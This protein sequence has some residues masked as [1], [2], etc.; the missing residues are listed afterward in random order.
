MRPEWWPWL[1]RALWVTLPFTAGPLFGDAFADTS[2]PVQLV[3]TI[4]L[5]VLW[6][7]G[8][9]CMLI[10]HV[11]TLTPVRMLA[12]AAAVAAIWATIDAGTSGTAVLGLVSTLAVAI[13]AASPH[14][15]GWFVNGSS[16][17]DERRL[18]LRPPT[19]IAWGPLPLAAA[20]VIA[21]AGAAPLL[22]AA[23]QWILGGLVLVIGGALAYPALRAMH[24]LG[25][26]WLVF[27]PA[28]MVIHDS[29]V[30]ADPVLIKRTA[31]DVFGPALADTTATDL[32]MAASG[33]VLEAQLRTP[34]SLALR[35]EPG[36]Q[37]EIQELEAVLVAPTLPGAVLDE[38]ERRRIRVG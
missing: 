2:R 25:R 1:L 18:L 7:A 24:T 32:T 10:P 11:L 31:I 8:L 4:G 22:L 15:G 34:A 21:T 12:P 27:V 37:P 13:T 16:Y 26:R 3:G 30:L 14:I 29:M 20:I 38:A 36:A 23:K 35:P 9:C 17:G 19:T 33:L 5:W 6:G 28:G